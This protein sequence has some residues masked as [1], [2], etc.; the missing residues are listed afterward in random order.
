MNVTAG[1]TNVSSGDPITVKVAISGRGALDSITLPD[2]PAWHEF[3]TFPPT[4]KVEMTDALGTQ[5]VKTFEQIIVPENAE[6]KELPPIS[7][8]YFDPEQKGY[9]TLTQP[10]IRLVVK[11]GGSTPAPVMA[12]A[13]RTSPENA[14]PAQDIVHIKPRLGQL[15]QIGPPLV[16]RHWFLALQSVPLLAFVSSLVLRKRAEMLAN[17]P[18]LTAPAAAG[19]S[20]GAGGSA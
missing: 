6:I 12:T 18:R 15:A 14:P 7:F 3:K 1:P 9:R 19:G 20:V 16:E 10:A 11:P 13:P 8:S 5:G 17:N 2:Q 4:S